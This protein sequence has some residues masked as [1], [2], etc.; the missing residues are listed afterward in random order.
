M[1]G[2]ERAILAAALEEFL[3][4]GYGGASLSRIVAR[5]GIS[6]TTLYRRYPDKAALFRAVLDRQMA[7]SRPAAPLAAS[8]GAPLR[9]EEGLVR[10]ADAML[11]FA[12]REEVRGVERLLCSEAH[13]FPELAAAAAARNA[14]GVER[15]AAFLA[16]CAAR[17]GMPCRDPHGAA[18]QFIALLR[19]WYLEVLETGR[20]VTAAERRAW[21]ER[22][23]ERFVAGRSAW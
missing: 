8:G 19:G 16:Q 10:Y 13:Q 2:R 11:A 17:D 20:R 12:L 5:A 14:R 4:R 1:A 3:A 23:V 9:L 22:A 7:R 6:K 18:D 15:I 21:V